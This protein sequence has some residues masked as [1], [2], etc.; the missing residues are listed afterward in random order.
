MEEVTTLPDDAPTWLVEKWD[1]AVTWHRFHRTRNIR[2]AGHVHQILLW[3]EDA[4]ENEMDWLDNVDEEGR[5]KKLLKSPSL[6]HLEK[7]MDKDQK[8]I[9]LKRRN[10]AA[11]KFTR[12]NLKTHFEKVMMFENGYYIVRIKTAQ[13]LD[14]EGDYLE[15]CIGNGEYAP[16]L[17]TNDKLFY[18]LRNKEDLPC[19]SMC[20]ERDGISNLTEIG[21]RRNA[22]P[23]AEYIRYIATFCEENLIRMTE[24]LSFKEGFLRMGNPLYFNDHT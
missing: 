13:A 8:Q 24:A 12:E 9:L 7:V 16:S 10:A 15:H 3:L 11:Q 18:S 22:M 1:P 14:L 17:K 23:K 5:P 21:A 4:I 20:V 6:E 19:V 2:L